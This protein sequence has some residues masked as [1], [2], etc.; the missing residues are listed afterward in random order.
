VCQSR[1]RWNWTVEALGVHITDEVMRSSAGYGSFLLTLTTSQLF[2]PVTPFALIE[3]LY[4]LCYPSGHQGGLPSFYFQL[5]L[6]MKESPA[7]DYYLALP[8]TQSYDRHVRSFCLRESFLSATMW[9]HRAVALYI[10]LGLLL[11]HYDFK[12]VL[13]S[14]F[15]DL[16]KTI[17]DLRV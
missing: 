5:W 16:G 17:C 10:L 6:N 1:R 3:I 12:V 9:L 2:F 13:P 7:V 4:F 14:F 11:F 8:T 15:S